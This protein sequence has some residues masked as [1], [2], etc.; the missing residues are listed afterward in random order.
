MSSVKI[1]NHRDI[2]L[3]PIVSEKSY[4]LRAANNYT[5][6]VHK[7]AHTTQIRQAIE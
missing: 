1:R 6:R 3:A 4:A 5:F 7:D 2:L